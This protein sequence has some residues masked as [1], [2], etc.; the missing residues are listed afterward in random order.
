M[1][2]VLGLVKSRDLRGHDTT[3]DVVG[4]FEDRDVE[5]ELPYYRRNFKADITGADDHNALRAFDLCAD[6]IDVVDAAQIVNAG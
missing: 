1:S 2:D 3:H 4:H 6:A 5:P